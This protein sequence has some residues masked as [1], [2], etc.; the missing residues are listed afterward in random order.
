MRVRRR[1][2]GHGG[3]EDG[4]YVRVGHAGAILSARAET[5]AVAMSSWSV[6]QRS[7]SMYNGVI[8]QADR[9]VKYSDLATRVAL[10]YVTRRRSG[11]KLFSQPQLHGGTRCTGTSVAS[12]SYISIFS[13]LIHARLVQS[14]TISGTVWWKAETPWAPACAGLVTNSNQ[15]QQQP[16]IGIL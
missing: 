8:V 14:S 12:I 10:L 5:A 4:K 2:K 16:Y 9:E 13:P 15:P 11:L 1:H 6:T 7:G 3:S